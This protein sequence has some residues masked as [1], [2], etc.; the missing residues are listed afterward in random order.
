MSLKVLGLTDLHRSLNAA[1]G[2]AN[3]I[4]EE[5]PDAILIAGDISHGSLNEAV[6]LLQVLSSSQKDVF[7]VPGNMDSPELMNWNEKNIKN[8]HGRCESLDNYSLIGVGGS[9][10]TPFN[11]HLEFAENEIEETLSQAFFKCAEKKNIILISHCPPK[12]TKLDRT[13]TGIHA[14]ST[15]VLQFIES[16]K[17]LLVVTGH[18]HEAIGIDKIGE[19]I[20]VNP[21]PAHMGRY[22]IIEFGKKIHVKLK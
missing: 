17:P 8:L 13:A 6:N 18:I 4:A 14:G 11:T 20:I 21:G 7:F 3:K 19:T 2:A 22:V 1:K 12:D 9:V 5:Q 10:Y 16:K 15:S